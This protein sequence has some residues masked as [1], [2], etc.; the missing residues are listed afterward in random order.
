MLN[1]SV[2]HSNS[3]FKMNARKKLGLFSNKQWIGIKCTCSVYTWLS[4]SISE[5]H[6]I[7]GGPKKKHQWLLNQEL[8]ETLEETTKLLVQF[9]RTIAIQR[10]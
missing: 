3:Y 2:E 1:Y 5:G 4:E 8:S 9:L 10:Q 7:T 6:Q